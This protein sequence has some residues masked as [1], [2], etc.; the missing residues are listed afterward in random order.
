VPDV[1]AAADEQLERVVE[2]G[3]IRAVLLQ[4][5]PAGAHP[6]GVALQRVDLAVVAEETERLRALPRRRG[7]RGEPLVKDPERDGEVGVAQVGVEAVELVGRA[8]GLVGDRPE[9]ERRDVRAGRRLG[10]LPCAVGTQLRL[11]GRRSERA[12]EHELLDPR[13]RRARCFAERRGVD[14]HRTPARG[15]DSLCEAGGLDRG[16]GVL[17][18]Q[19]HLCEPAPRRGNECARDRQEQPGAVTAD[20]VRRHGAAM[21]HAGE[22]YQQAVDDGPGRPAGRVGQEADAAG[23]AL[24]AWVGS[25]VH[26]TCAF[27]E[28]CRSACSCDLAGVGGG[29]KR[30]LARKDA[31]KDRGNDEV[32]GVRAGHDASETR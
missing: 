24:C 5:V 27:L 7:V 21:R 30:R 12:P 11:V 17:V 14:R 8:Q 29:T 3:G 19:E 13:H 1:A 10:P 25:A 16:T 15:L 4:H 2:H 20:A 31:R 6:R 18:A 9:G 22:P 23:I 32:L 26:G 28:E